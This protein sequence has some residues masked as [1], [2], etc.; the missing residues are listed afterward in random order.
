MITYFET[1]TYTVTLWSEVRCY[2]QTFT[3]EAVKVTAA[4]VGNLERQAGRKKLY[5]TKAQKVHSA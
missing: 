4:T 5:S 1:C 2:M 3:S